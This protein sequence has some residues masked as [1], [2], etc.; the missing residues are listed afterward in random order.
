VLTQNNPEEKY[1]NL[2]IALNASQQIQIYKI[3]GNLD[4]DVTYLTLNS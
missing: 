3:L 4:Q 2:K 1:R